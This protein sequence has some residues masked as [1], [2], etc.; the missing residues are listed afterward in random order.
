M[1]ESSTGDL[2]VVVE[3]DDRMRS[4]IVEILCAEGLRAVGAASGEEGLRIARESAPR[5]VVLDVRLPGVSGHEVCRE[6]RRELGESVAIIYVSG[7][8]IESY[9]RVAG[10][11]IGGDDYLVKP[12]APDELCARVR[13]LMRRGPE[14]DGN[15]A[16]SLTPRENEVLALLAGGLDQREIA[17][18]LVISGR[19]VGTHIERVLQKLG[20]H[21]RTQAVAV[22]YRRR[23][24]KQ[25]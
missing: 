13:A 17:V 22:A 19:T 3:D 2:A 9:D 24:V 14:R 8:R 5:L 23:L 12:F 4:L 18:R 15:S 1:E 16:P 25:G 20:V 11:L 6:L 21:N 10:L 7:E